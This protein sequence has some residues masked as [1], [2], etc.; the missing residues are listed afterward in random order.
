MEA[1]FTE[2]VLK[3]KDFDQFEPTFF[4]AAIAAIY[5]KKGY[6]VTLTPK[7]NDK[8]ADIVALSENRNYLIQVKQS[9]SPINGNSVGEVLKA[10]GYYEK[11]Y[12]EQFYLKVATNNELNS[13]AIMLADTNNVETFGRSAIQ[14]FL[15]AEELFLSAIHEIEDK[16]LARI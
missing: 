13:N 3:L 16:R 7:S 10:K 6:Q 2:D 4:E 1:H 5:A 8:G 12:N 14:T 11:I 9:K 15:K